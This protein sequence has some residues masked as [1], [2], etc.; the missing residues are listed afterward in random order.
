MQP[1]PV[2]DSWDTLMQLN[3]DGHPSQHPDAV[4]FFGAEAERMGVTIMALQD[5]R[6]GAYNGRALTRHIDVGR[7]MEH[8]GLHYENR[9]PEQQS[10]GMN[11]TKRHFGNLT[12]NGNFSR[13]SPS[14]PTHRHTTTMPQHHDAT[15]RELHRRNPKRTTTQP[16]EIYDH[17][18]AHERAQKE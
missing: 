11:V 4:Q 16:E 17:T 7:R 2:K 18:E 13:T 8:S 15:R 5:T 3:I 12:I 1:K 14:K 6:R 9:R 10:R